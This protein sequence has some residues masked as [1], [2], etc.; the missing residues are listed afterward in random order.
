MWAAGGTGVPGKERVYLLRQLFGLLV[1]DM[2]ASAIGYIDL[3]ALAQSG[4]E[5]LIFDLDN[6]LVPWGS[7][8][9]DD[10]VLQWF[11]GARRRFR[12]GMVSNA[13]TERVQ[14]WGDRLG[15]P[16]VARAAK[17]RRGGYREI[18]EQMGEC[19]ERVAVIGDQMFTDVV[20]GNR[21]GMITVLVVPLSRREFIG[22]RMVRCVERAVLRLLVG[23]G[24]TRRLDGSEGEVH[25]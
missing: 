24:L 1:P 15:I 18:L 2:Y 10:E 7:D 6:T 16:A 13:L 17:P 25:G 11:R 19:P 21:M 20:G 5:V 3:D 12:L 23:R 22:T 4:V 14:Y 9:M 8:D